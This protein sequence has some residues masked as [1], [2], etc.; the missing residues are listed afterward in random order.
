MVPAINCLSWGEVNAGVCIFSPPRLLIQEPR[1]QQR[2]GLV[3]MPCY[4]VSYLIVGQPRL[5]LST[6]KTFLDP[7]RRLSYPR[8]FLQIHVGLGIRQLNYHRLE[9]GG[10]ISRL[11]A[12]LRQAGSPILNPEIIVI[13]RHFL[14]PD[15][16]HD[17]L[18]AHVA[19]TRR[20]ESPRPH[21]PTPTGL[22]QVAVLLHQ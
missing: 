4:P 14:R 12:R 6:L 10:F 18:V 20:E 22:L 9:A 7:M 21:M 16:L 2:Q 5:T 15:V 3:M 11:K 13:L 17:H 8:K 19:R 1:G